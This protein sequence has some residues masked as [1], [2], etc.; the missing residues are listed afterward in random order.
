MNDPL[1]V[2]LATYLKKL[3]ELIVEEGKFVLIHGEDVVG[4]FGAYEDALK[5]GY[6]AFKLDP[7]LVKNITS[8]EQIQFFTRSI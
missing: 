6:E 1:Q 3:P 5:A 2:E 7:F 8:E 4:I